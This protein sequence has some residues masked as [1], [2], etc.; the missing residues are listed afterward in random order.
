[1][2][3]ELPQHLCP[4]L[5]GGGCLYSAHLWLHDRGCR[6][7]SADTGPKACGANTRPSSHKKEV[8]RDGSSLTAAC[9][10]ECIQSELNVLTPLLRLIHWQASW[11]IIIIII[12]SISP[13]WCVKIME[14]FIFSSNSLSHVFEL[15]ACGET[16]SNDMWVNHFINSTRGKYIRAVATHH[17]QKE[18]H[19]L[20]APV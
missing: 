4:N 13:H 12:L 3:L 11:G 8:N 9:H 14:R 2:G 20:N 19:I 17:R 18:K 1:M 5:G 10:S 6:A 16:V 15:F 7:A